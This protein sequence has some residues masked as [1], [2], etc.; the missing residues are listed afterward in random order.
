MPTDLLLERAPAPPEALPAASRF[1]TL[2][3]YFAMTVAS[4]RRIEYIDGAIFVM[5]GVTLFHSSIQINMTRILLQQL[6]GSDYGI[7]SSNV[8][9]HIAPSTYFF[10]DLCAVRGAG[11]VARSGAALV[12]PVLVVEA[13]SKSTAH[14]DRGIDFAA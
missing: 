1:V 2:E 4:E 6:A 5:D 11:R 8:S 9:V 10:P 3:E 12:N 7:H 13:L 14:K